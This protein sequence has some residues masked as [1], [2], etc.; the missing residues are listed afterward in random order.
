MPIMEFAQPMPSS[1]KDSE[2]PNKIPPMVMMSGKIKYLKSIIKMGM[3]IAANQ[4]KLM[5]LTRFCSTKQIP[6]F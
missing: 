6:C 3:R 4:N 2:S 1:K 5:L